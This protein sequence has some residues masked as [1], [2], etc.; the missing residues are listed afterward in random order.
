MIYIYLWAVCY[1]TMFHSW[2]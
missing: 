1:P 2:D